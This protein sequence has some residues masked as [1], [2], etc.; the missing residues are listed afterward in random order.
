VK[1]FLI[2]LKKLRTDKGISYLDIENY[3]EISS[4]KMEDFEE[5]KKNL[6]L[7]ELEKL[8]EYHK[9]TYDQ[10]LKYKNNK[11]SKKLAI[12]TLF[13]VVFLGTFFFYFS[14]NISRNEEVS[15]KAE[16]KIDD[17]DGISSTINSSIDENKVDPVAF[18]NADQKNTSEKEKVIIRFWGNIP[19]DTTNLPQIKE[20]NSNHSIDIVPIEKLNNIR[21]DWLQGIDRDHLILNAGAS[22][23]WTPST[24]EAYQKLKEDKV[25]IFG[26]GTTPDVYD[27]YIIQINSKKVG[28]LSLAGLIHNS[29]EISLNSRIGLLRAYREDEVM[30][31]VKEAKE[32]VD[33]LFV[34]IDWGK[35]WS[36]T[37]NF[38]QKIIAEA[39]VRGGGDFIIG[40]HPI[41]SQDI[42]TI[43]GKPVFYGLGHSISSYAKESSYNFVIETDFTSQLDKVRLKV[44]KMDQGVITFDLSPDDKKNIQATVDEKVRIMDN[45]E[46]DY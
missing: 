7:G 5:G 38:S 24:I 12:V 40:N 23:I 37:H 32:K 36:E 45:F 21:P 19:Y 8:L 35:T 13:I 41:H 30:K 18:M 1:R 3:T 20:Q 16:I 34:L 4:R 6:T 46:F 10:V 2:Q 44:G 11:L 25:N 9:M 17:L 31:V 15:E 26:L 43:D 27:P 14:S 29:S 28:F 39:I 42:G 33:Y 22:D